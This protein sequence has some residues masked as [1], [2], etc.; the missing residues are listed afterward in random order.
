[1][2]LLENKSAI[3]TGAASGI[4]ETSAKM[5]AEEGASVVVADVDVENGRETATD[6]QE[7]GGEAT[8]VETDVSDEADAA[9]MVETAVETYGG[10]D[11]L[12]NNA[13]IEG[14]VVK[15]AD[16]TLEEFER[17]VDVNLKGTWL[18]TK[19]GIE[20]MLEDGGGSIISTSSI[21]SERTIPEY[22]AY[23]ASKSGINQLMR[24]V[25]IEYIEDD[26]RAN[27]IAPGLVR[28]EMIERVLED[29]DEDLMEA[30]D[31]YEPMPPRIAETEDIAD[32]AVFLA[33]ERS[34][35]IT[36]TLLPVEGGYL[37]EGKHTLPASE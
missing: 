30:L 20:A 34:E 4:G 27:A 37:S 14:P 13:G 11:V 26:I 18:G 22:A 3:I 8:F 9:E 10:L 32:A 36:G 15:T 31:I 21:G 17:V 19:Y 33:S 35:R 1:M 2:S 16:H 12:F 6:I 28:T 5:F 29:T 24:V 23:G 7:A 25:A